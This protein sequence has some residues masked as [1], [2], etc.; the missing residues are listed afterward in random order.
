V[1]YIQA[2]QAYVQFNLVGSRKGHFE[3]AV[4]NKD[5]QTEL[6]N[7]LSCYKYLVHQIYYSII[8]F[9]LLLEITYYLNTGSVFSEFFK[10]SLKV[11]HHHQFA[12]ADL[13]AI[14]HIKCVGMFTIYL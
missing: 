3:E 2:A 12:T 14:I 5:F 4:N 9:I 11:L 6:I 1:A 10:H 8:N 13:Q 7:L